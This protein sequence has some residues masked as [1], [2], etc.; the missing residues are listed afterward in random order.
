MDYPELAFILF[1]REV[2]ADMQTPS[3]EA[4]KAESVPAACQHKNTVSH[5]GKA[6]TCTDSGYT[7]DTVCVSCEKVIAAGEEV[8]AKGHA[9][10]PVAGK[11]ATTEDTGI[12]DRFK[13]S[14][15]GKLFNGD[16][17]QLQ[18]GDLILDKLTEETEAPKEPIDST[19]V[20][21]GIVAA[22]ALVSVC[23]VVAVRCKERGSEKT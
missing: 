15:C 19:A 3:G 20:I 9:L 4:A 10:N 12:A 21:M 5:A 7:G 11:P 18:S 14:A 13:C 2:P 22:T 17:K 6:A 23:V 1:G 8:A 16:G